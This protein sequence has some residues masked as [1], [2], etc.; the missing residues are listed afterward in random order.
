MGPLSNAPGPTSGGIQD[1][2]H[3]YKGKVDDNPETLKKVSD[4]ILPECRSILWCKLN[5]FFILGATETWKKYAY[6]YPLL[7]FPPRIDKMPSGRRNPH[8]RMQGQDDLINHLVDHDLS[9]KAMCGV[10]RGSFVVH[11]KAISRGKRFAQGNWMRK[12]E[13]T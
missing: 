11:Y 7:M 3:Y 10:S 13:K 5:G 4:T 2:A 12:K 9:G 1:I 8:P 6:Q